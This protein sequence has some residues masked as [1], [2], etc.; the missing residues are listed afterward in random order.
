MTRDLDESDVIRD[1]ERMGEPVEIAFHVV[2]HTARIRELRTLQQWSNLFALE[3]DRDIATWNDV[4]EAI[5]LG[6]LAG[7]DYADY[8]HGS[9]VERT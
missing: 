4:D 8:V 7:G 5:A 1:A 6:F 2:L 3:H 9:Y